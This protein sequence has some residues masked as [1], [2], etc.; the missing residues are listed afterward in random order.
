MAKTNP[1]WALVSEQ[2]SRVTRLTT[3]HFATEEAVMA[4]HRM[5]PEL[6]AAHCE[7]HQRIINDVAEFHLNAM[8]GRRESIESIA[9]MM[10]DWI[11]YH[12][13]EFDR[14]LV[15]LLAKPATL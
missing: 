1:D 14:H 5:S 15:P 4:E 6:L 10:H 13:H 12:L 3:E 9:S 8:A 11:V 2:L 7:D